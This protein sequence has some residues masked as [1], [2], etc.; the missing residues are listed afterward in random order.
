MATQ[1]KNPQSSQYTKAVVATGGKQYLVSLGSK[2]IVEKLVA[3][4]G[5][6]ITLSDIRMIGKEGSIS[7]SP[8]SA[9]VTAEVLAQGK[10]DKIRVF[11]YKSKKR[12]RRTQGHRQSLTTL[13]VVAING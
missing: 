2:F 10:G 11:K 12:Y 13:K 1:P 8:T 7:L 4:P 3:E 9:S 5:E 6:Q